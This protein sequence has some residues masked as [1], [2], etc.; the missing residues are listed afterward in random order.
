MTMQAQ[1]KELKNMTT[2]YRIWDNANGNFVGETYTAMML[3]AN[4]AYWL[5]VRDGRKYSVRTWTFD[6]KCGYCPN[7]YTA[8]CPNYVPHP[9]D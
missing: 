9:F 2:T 1:P 8:A 4:A 6:G 7:C 3:A 5:S